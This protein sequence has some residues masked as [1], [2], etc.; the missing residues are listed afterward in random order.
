MSGSNR[1]PRRPPPPPNPCAALVINSTVNSPNAQV[2]STLK[3]GDVLDVVLL[4]GGQSVI[5]QHQ[6]NVVGALTGAHIA[7]LI[8]CMNSGFLYQAIVQTLNGGQCVVRVEAI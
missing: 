4:P 7:R 5:V 1:G 6:G 8:D 3:V 2:L